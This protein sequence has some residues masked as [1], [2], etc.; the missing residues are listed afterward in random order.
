VLSQ[1][2]LVGL[3]RAF[4]R[5]G[6]PAT[7]QLLTTLLIHL[8]VAKYNAARAAALGLHPDVARLSGPIA[9]LALSSNFVRLAA[10]VSRVLGPRLTA[11][12]GEWG[13][14]A[15]CDVVLGVPGYRIGGGTDEILRN[16]IAER[17]L[18]LPRDEAASRSAT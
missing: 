1:D 11:D 4:D 7:R 9:K 17:V 13:A 2:R 10:Y 6:V 8:K 3:A 16:V 15:W 5:A 12:T 18:G 14:Y